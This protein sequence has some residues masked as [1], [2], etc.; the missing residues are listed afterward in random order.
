HIFERFYRTDTARARSSGGAGLGLAIAKWIAEAHGGRI[1]ISSEPGTG[2]AF[3][4]WLPLLSSES[5]APAAVK[6]AAY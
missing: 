4:I 3:T 5:S 6:I 2:S 1:T